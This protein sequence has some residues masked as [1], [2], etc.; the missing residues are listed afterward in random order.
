[1]TKLVL[2]AA[3]LSLIGCMGDDP[4][5]TEC[6]NKGGIPRT[7]ISD[8]DRGVRD[9]FACE[10]VDQR[11]VPTVPGYVESPIPAK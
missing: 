7:R 8:K 6:K 3:L 1:M 11:I 5:I 9:L 10:F 2:L 4:G